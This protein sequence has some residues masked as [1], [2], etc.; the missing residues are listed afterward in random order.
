MRTLGAL[1]A[2]ILLLMAH[3]LVLTHAESNADRESLQ[4]TSEDIRTA[5]AQ[6]DVD[7]NGGR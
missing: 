2:L 3:R 1:A 7:S 5:F 4:K 6:G